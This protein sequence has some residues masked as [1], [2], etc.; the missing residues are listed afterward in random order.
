MCVSVSALLINMSKTHSTR[1]AIIVIHCDSFR[2]WTKIIMLI[3]LTA[4]KKAIGS[5]EA[6]TNRKIKYSQANYNIIEHYGIY[7]AWKQ[8]KKMKKERKTR[9]KSFT[10]NRNNIYARIHTFLHIKRILYFVWDAKRHMSKNNNIDILV[11]QM[12]AIVIMN[13][14][15][16]KFQY[17]FQW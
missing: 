1:P 16:D 4:I 17:I 11:T 12:P 8:S 3:M 15:T 9:N 10:N 2:I 14:K 7:R 5:N 6:A 13:T